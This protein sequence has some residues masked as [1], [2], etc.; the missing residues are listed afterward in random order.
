MLLQMNMIWLFMWC[1]DAMAM[2]SV[3]L[4]AR[5][6][7]ESH[8][9]SAARNHLLI[10]DAWQLRRSWSPLSVAASILLKVATR[11][12]NSLRKES[13]KGSFVKSG[14]FNAQFHL[15]ST[16]LFRLQVYISSVSG[17]H[18]NLDQMLRLDPL[19]QIVIQNG[20]LRCILGLDI[21]RWANARG[22]TTCPSHG[23]KGMW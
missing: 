22:T 2:L 4:A 9:P 17:S 20:E 8:V 5:S 23:Y 3:Q 6:S 16:N 10:H 18:V 15:V 14:Q 19:S 7:R 1:N 13:M 21:S 11:W 12:W